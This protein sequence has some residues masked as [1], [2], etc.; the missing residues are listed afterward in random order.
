M[1]ICHIF[2]I[3]RKIILEFGR[4]IKKGCIMAVIIK[5]AETFFERFEH[6][7][8]VWADKVL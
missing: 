2:S 7:L 3:I 8:E 1:T 4:L 5:Q 6:T